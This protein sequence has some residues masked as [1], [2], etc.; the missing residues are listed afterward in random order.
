MQ[1][2]RRCAWVGAIALT[3]LVSCQQQSGSVKLGG[4]GEHGTPPAVADVNHVSVMMRPPLIDIDGDRRP[5]GVMVYIYLRHGNDARPV[6]G[7][8][9][10]TIRLMQ[11]VK[12]PEGR[13]QDA[14]LKAWKI[15]PEELH[16]A[17]TRDR[18]GLWCYRMELYWQKVTVPERGAFLLGEFTRP[19][20][21]TVRSQSLALV[22]MPTEG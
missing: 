6:P 7:Q 8:G 11:R 20:G 13:P 16:R 19:D 1:K 3:M 4:T 10:L 15:P 22:G 14:E 5:D 21:Q 18:F 17:M 2:S 12:G 9:D